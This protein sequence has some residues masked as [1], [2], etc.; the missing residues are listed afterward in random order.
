MQGEPLHQGLPTQPPLIWLL[1]GTGDGPPL[2][3]ALLRRGWRLRV[4]VVGATATRAYTPHPLLTLQVGDLADDGA[5]EREL[6]QH[7]PRWVVDATHPFARR[8]SERL[9]RVC[10]GRDQALLRLRRPEL[11]ADLGPEQ[12]SCEPLNGLGALAQLDL[13]HERLLLAIGSR[14]LP[15]A[16]AASNAAAH[17]ARILDRPASLQLALAAGLSD[18]Q[19]ACLHPSGTPQSGGPEAGALE[20]AL[21]RRW[22][23][24]AVLCRAGGGRSEAV[25]HGVAQQLGLR[26]LVL[27]RPAGPASEGLPLQPLLEKLGHP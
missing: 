7:R 20:R 14:Q 17:F 6:A 2:A 15:Q 26:L 5:V 22:R 10:G 27:Q 9:E 24:S 11:G 4:S 21:C 12:G 1:A 8:I 3:A 18:G 16:M 19:L 13:S 25:W 23:I